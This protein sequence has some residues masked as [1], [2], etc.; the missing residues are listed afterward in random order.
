MRNVD[1]L[2][3]FQEI[4][5]VFTVTPTTSIQHVGGMRCAA[6]TRKIDMPVIKVQVMNRVTRTQGKRGRRFGDIFHDEIRIESHHGVI[7]VN[8]GAGFSQDLSGFRQ[9]K[10]H[11][12]FSQHLKGC[13][14]Q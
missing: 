9:G 3:Q 4:F 8:P 14:V 6:Y 12:V 11:A 10:P 2:C 7:F 13:R 1:Q 5:E